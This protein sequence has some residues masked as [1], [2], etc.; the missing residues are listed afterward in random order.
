MACQSVSGRSG[1]AIP[2]SSTFQMVLL[3]A[4]SEAVGMELEW[5]TTEK[6]VGPFS[7]DILCKN[8]FNDE[9]VL[10]ENQLEKTDHTHLGQIITYAAGLQASTVIWI[11]REFREEHRA[12]LDWL[13][14]HTSKHLRFFGVTIE[15]W[16]IGDS[17]P[18]PRLHV[19]ARPND[20]S[21][22]VEAA[23]EYSPR[24]LFCRKYWTAFNEVLEVSPGPLRPPAPA[25]G[26]WINFSIGKTSVYLA[27]VINPSSRWIR[28]EVYLAGTFAKSR[29]QQ[30]IQHKEIIEQ[31]TGALNWQELVG[32]QDCRIS[33]TRTNTNPADESDWSNQHEW[34]RDNMKRLHAAFSPLVKQLKDNAASAPPL[35]IASGTETQEEQD[36]EE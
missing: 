25:K 31:T 32:R 10:I 14:E 9:W 36:S 6:A 30:L 7:A 5:E 12:A 22:S 29:F 20:W 27:A 1:F 11:A 28:A 21:K 26:S 15:L 24:Q 4:L 16:R 34:L 3:G 8:A 17:V 2:G 23:K 33:L 19:V 35:G 18:A 13:N